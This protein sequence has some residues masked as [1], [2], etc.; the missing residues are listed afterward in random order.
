M[1]LPKRRHSVS[2]RNKRRANWKLSAPTLVECASC[3]NP[4]LPHTVCPSC[5]F[6]GGEVVWTTKKRK[7]TKT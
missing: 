7:A 2:R 1:A 6:Y 3:S 5:G 4:R